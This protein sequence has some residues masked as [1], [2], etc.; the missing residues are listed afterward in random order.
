MQAFRVI[1]S[2]CDQHSLSKTISDIAKQSYK[3][4]D[5]EKLLRGKNLDAVIAA[6]IFI[7]CR[8]AH[9]PRTFPEICNLTH[10]WCSRQS[11]DG[12]RNGSKTSGYVH[13]HLFIEPELGLTYMFQF[14]IAL[15]KDLEVARTLAEL[16]RKREL[17]KLKQAQIIHEIISNL[18]FHTQENCVPLLR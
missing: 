8:Q 12:Q 6:C 11:T 9:V 16:A 18:V 14:S 10:V 4:S 3:L 2:W 15:R 13:N 5:G 1:S 7:A 17:H